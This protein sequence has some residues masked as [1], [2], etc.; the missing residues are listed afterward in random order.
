VANAT[1]SRVTAYLASFERN[2]LI[3]R[4]GRQLI[5]SRNRLEKFLA[6]GRSL[7]TF[8]K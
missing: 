8:A 2:H 4:D 6:Q 7:A 3:V 1:L 5:V